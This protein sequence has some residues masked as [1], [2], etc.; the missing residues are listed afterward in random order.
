[1]YFIVSVDIGSL[2]WY[3][4]RKFNDTIGNENFALKLVNRFFKL[5]KCF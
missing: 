1:M 3:N 2:M 5:H 4:S